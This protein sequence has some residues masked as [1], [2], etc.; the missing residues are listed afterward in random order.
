MLDTLGESAFSNKLDDLQN[1]FHT[2]WQ[3]VENML[4]QDNQPYESS[5]VS[6][7]E[8]VKSTPLPASPP[9]SPGD[10]QLGSP[11]Q[12]SNSATVSPA[13]SNSS[14]TSSFCNQDLYDELLDLDFILSNTL[15]PNTSFY[16]EDMGLKIK[17]EPG[18]VNE[19]L[20]SFHSAFNDIPD[21]K[22]DAFLS[23]VEN[24]NTISPDAEMKK[25]DYSKPVIPKQEFQQSMTN[26]CASYNVN[27][28]MPLARQNC[29]P[30]SP[31]PQQLHYSA[32]NIPG[33]LSPPSSPELYPEQK[34]PVPLPA[35]MHQ[36]SP[37]RP[38]QPQAQQLQQQGMA[39]PHHPLQQ[40]HMQ[41]L[42]PPH[43]L[44]MSKLGQTQLSLPHMITPPSSPQQLVDLL[45]PQT[46][47]DPSIV[48]PKKRGRRTWGRKRQTTHTCSHPG[49]SKTYT[50][51]SHLKAHL[52]THTGEKPYR[53]TW[54]GCG[55]RFA[56]SDE[57]TRHFRKHTGDRPFQCHL[58]ERAFSRSDHLS[59]HMKRHI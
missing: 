33:Q 32:M 13:P 53:C 57:L 25:V 47:I 28:T 51:S 21:I 45:L 12:R 55:W 14:T 17:Q 3:D 46:P 8:Q 37:F 31:Q 27:Q 22:Y 48:Q 52:R 7:M 9:V 42:L 35:M 4:F 43:L 38:S 23:H 40:Q 26:S 56:R 44:S 59:L 2:T 58:C 19:E 11:L 16:S 18:L 10:S 20:P 54:K 36:R 6:M 39:L 29:N 1:E 5:M 50:K 30:M 41:Y 49:C 15:D 24:M 34:C